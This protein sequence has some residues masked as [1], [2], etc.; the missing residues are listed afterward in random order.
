MEFQK[1]FSVFLMISK[2]KKWCQL[3]LDLLKDDKNYK[4]K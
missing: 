4:I 3:K 1:K 2:L